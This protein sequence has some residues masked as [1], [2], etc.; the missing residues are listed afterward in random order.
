[1]ARTATAEDPHRDQPVLERGRPL[2]SADAAVVLLHGR[3][4]S[5]EDILSL[6]DEFDL[7]DLAYLA[8]DAAGHAWYPHSF[9]APIEQNQPWLDSALRLVGSV[10]QHAVDEGVPRDKVVLAGFSQGACLAS[11]FVARNP[12]RYGGLIAYTGGLVGPPETKFAFPGKLDG[13]PCLLAAGDP[14]PH[15]PWKRVQETANA[16]SLLGGVV[17]LQHYPGLPHTINREEIE[18]GR[19]LLAGVLAGEN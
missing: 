17:K 14:D 11:E 13:T 2:A 18:L 10:V 8:P 5:A 16:L 6:A 3:G 1:M 9:L 19:Q 15:V 12:A 4:A 7:P